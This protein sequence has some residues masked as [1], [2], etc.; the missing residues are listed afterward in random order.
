MEIYRWQ[1]S[2][3]TPLAVRDTP[4]GPHG[5][6]RRGAG[7]GWVGAGDTGEGEIAAVT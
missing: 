4:P 7:P 6:A 2:D 5:S 1:C 3:D